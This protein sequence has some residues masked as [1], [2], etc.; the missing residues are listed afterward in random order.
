MTTGSNLG[1]LDTRRII[2]R[3]IYWPDWKYT[4]LSPKH[5]KLWKSDAKLVMVNA[6][7][8]YG[9]DHILFLRGIKLALKLYA[10]RKSNPNWFRY[11]PTVEMAVFAPVAKNFK[12]LWRRFKDMLPEV[13]GIAKGGGKNLKIYERENGYEVELF[14]PTGIHIT[15][16]SAYDEDSSRGNGYDILLGT[17][18]AYADESV[19]TVSLF[20]LVIRPNYAGYVMLNSTPWGPGNWWDN[21]VREARERTGFWGNYEL[22]EGTFVDNPTSCQSDID[23]ARREKEANVYTYR[24]E[25]LAWLEIP[26]V[27]DNVLRA[28]NANQFA[29]QREHI[30]AA[31]TDVETPYTGACYA[32]SDIAWSGKDFLWTVII[33]DRTGLVVHAEFHAEMTDAQIVEHMEKIKLK[34]RPKKHAYDCNG[35]LAMKLEGKLKHLNLEPIITQ[36]HGPNSK[37]EYVKMAIQ[38]FVQGSIK[39]P[40]PDRYPGLTTEMKQVYNELINQLREYRRIQVLKECVEHGRKIQKVFVTYSKKPGGKDDA[41]DALVLALLMRQIRTSTSAT[42]GL[43]KACRF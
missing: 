15:F 32:G 34:W 1:A 9:K 21:A 42:K 14:G 24:R 8:A 10:E 29:F 7:R 37:Y 3:R 39:I 19:L 38:H 23:N 26:R 13:P 5:Y 11:G 18:V 22:H 17:E 2:E 35:P 20:K 25:R 40:N 4:K 41:V 43:S 6:G 33:D 28:S 16:F 31:L 30:D 36:F 12:G 27:D